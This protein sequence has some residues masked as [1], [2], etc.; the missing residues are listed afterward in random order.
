VVWFVADSEALSYQGTPNF[1]KSE[2]L[3]TGTVTA[4][5]YTTCC[6]LAIFFIVF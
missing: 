6:T 2:D 4:I 5:N 1:N 3:G